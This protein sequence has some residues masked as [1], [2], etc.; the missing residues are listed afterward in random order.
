VLHRAVFVTF[1]GLVA[2]LAGQALRRAVTGMLPGASLHRAWPHDRAHCFFAR[3][4]RELDQAGLGLAQAAVMLLVPP[5]ADLRVAAGD[6]VFPSAGRTARAAARQHDGSSPFRERERRARR[7][8]QASRPRRR[9]RPRR[10]RGRPRRA[11]P[12]PWPRC[13]RSRP[14]TGPRTPAPPITG[15]RRP[16]AR[17]PHPDLPDRN[18]ARYDLAPP[19]TGKRGRPRTRG[20]RPGEPG[21]ITETCARET[22]TIRAYGRDQVKHAAEIPCL[23]HGPLRTAP[24]RLTVSR[25]EDTTEGHDRALVTTAMTAGPAALAARHATRRETGQ[26]SGDARNVPGAGEARTRARRAAGRTV[27]LAMPTSAIAVLWHARHGYDPAGIDD[28]PQDQPWYAR[29]TEPA[30][31]D[32]LANLRRVLI[33]ARIS[34]GSPAQP[35]PQETRAVTAAWAAAAA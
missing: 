22:R 20:A 25:D 30:P 4:R 7:G 32:T 23:W 16:P 35:T 21:D 13:P 9:K 33:T 14:R 12:R 6:S 15:P 1:C 10:R 3:A 28:R 2:G 8:P 29:K 17:E 27:P 18:A 5:D 11:P 34:G 26:A 31:E 24:V 19:R